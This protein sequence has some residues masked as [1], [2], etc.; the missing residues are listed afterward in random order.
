MTHTSELASE[1]IVIFFGTIISIELAII[2][3]V[4]VIK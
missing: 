3:M 4:L 1:E 2:M